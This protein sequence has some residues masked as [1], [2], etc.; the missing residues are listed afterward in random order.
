MKDY[1]LGDRVYI[2]FNPHGGPAR[3]VGEVVA[4]EPRA[5]F[6]GEDLFYVAYAEPGAAA[7]A[8]MPFGRANLR[9]GSREELLE[10]AVWHEREAVRLRELASTETPTDGPRGA[11]ASHNESSPSRA[12]GQRGVNHEQ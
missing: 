8:T 11:N 4:V 12:Q 2:R 7:A 6:G 3:I 9:P 1:E 10:V 5:G